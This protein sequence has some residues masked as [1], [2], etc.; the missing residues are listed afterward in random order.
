MEFSIS[1]TEPINVV[2]ESFELPHQSIA[3]RQPDNVDEPVKYL[4]NAKEFKKDERTIKEDMDLADRI[5]KYEAII[6]SG[7]DAIVELLVT[8]II[9]NPTG[10]VKLDKIL[11][12]FV[13]Y[14]NY[15]NNRTV[16]GIDELSSKLSYETFIKGNSFPFEY[17]GLIK[18]GDI[19]YYG[20][21]F[22]YLLNPQRIT[23][24]PG[25]EII[26]NQKL[27]YFKSADIVETINGDGRKSFDASVMKRSIKRSELV[28]IHRNEHLSSGLELNPK[29]VTH[30]RRKAQDYEQWGVPYLSR[31]F[32]QVAAL[33]RLRQLDESTIESLINLIT[34]FK[35][36][37][38]E[39]PASQ[40]RLQA[41][42]NLLKDPKATHWLVWGH[43]FDAQQIGPD[44]KTLQL[45]DLYAQRYQE[46]F[47]ALSIPPILLGISGDA[48][49][50]DSYNQMLVLASRLEAWRNRLKIYYEKLFRKIAVANDFK[51]VPTMFW[52]DL[53]LNK[54]VYFKEF[55]TSLYDR[56]VMSPQTF[57]K[58]ANVDFD[59]MVTEFEEFKKSKVQEKFNVGVP[60]AL[61]FSGGQ[62]TDNRNSVQ[63]KKPKQQQIDKNKN[64]MK[65]KASEIVETFDEEVQLDQRDAINRFLWGMQDLSSFLQNIV[66]ETGA[67]NE[68]IPV[69]FA[70]ACLKLV[71]FY[72]SGYNEGYKNIFL[73]SLYNF[74]DSL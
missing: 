65:T 16:H 26:G 17:W 55:A 45:K 48:Q 25:N 33:H 32:S 56:G 2:K 59:A 40:A 24:Q 67:V 21:Q 68:N 49:G 31:A 51:E 28:K 64:R 8:K 57:A 53:E 6:G 60:P 23:I 27:F 66:Q 34:V 46:I 63:I 10:N 29:F 7:M 22:I 35:I 72:Q 43:D 61:P 38:E 62:N 5:Y 13:K 15:G 19:E 54:D 30:L 18:D 71:E 74:V 1:Y 20:P 12:H 36:G 52:S 3:I 70:Q 14:V 37:T 58:K 69:I 39:R 50:G 11:Q 44:G 9:L 73:E 47:I 42:A 41:F 4:L